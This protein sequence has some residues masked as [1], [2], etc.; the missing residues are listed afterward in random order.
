MYAGLAAGVVII[1][2]SHLAPFVGAGNYIRDLDQ[3]TAFG[4]GITRRE[5]HLVGVL[6]HL[7]FSLVSGGIY[8]WL[9]T[10]GWVTGFHF[11]SL[12]GWSVI[13]LLFQGCLV[14]PLEGHGF[15]GVKHDAW[16]AV[17]A[18]LT[19]ILWAMLFLFFL[20]LWTTV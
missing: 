16:F 7:L 18:F 11:L 10:Q 6:V 14:M 15:F 13:C 3:P 2:G 12:L 1:L 20:P 8:A 9:V 19:N 17:D 4:K 5:A